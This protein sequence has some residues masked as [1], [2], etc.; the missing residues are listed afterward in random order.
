VQEQ[1]LNATNYTAAAAA[2][3]GDVVETKLF[4]DKF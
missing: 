4:W 2:V 3:G 1:T